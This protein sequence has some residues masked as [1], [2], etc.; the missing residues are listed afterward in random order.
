MIID[1]TGEDLF[2]GNLLTNIHLYEYLNDCSYEIGIKEIILEIK[3]GQIT[4]KDSNWM[5]CSNLT[6]RCSANPKRALAFCVLNPHKN[7][8]HFQFSPI[9]FH[10]LERIHTLPRFEFRPT[11]KKANLK[12]KDLLIRLEIKRKCSDFQNHSKIWTRHHLLWSKPSKRGNV[13]DTRR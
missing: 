9:S 12:I 11:F 1:F 8:Y 6:D 2:N 5:I 3:S 10:V 4:E 7:R 13:N